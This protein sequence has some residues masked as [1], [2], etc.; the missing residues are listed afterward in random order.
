MGL[1]IKATHKHK[2]TPRTHT[3]AINTGS[4]CPT[5][6]VRTSSA[7]SYKSSCMLKGISDAARFMPSCRLLVLSSISH[8][9][10]FVK[11]NT[12]IRC[13]AFNAQVM[14]DDK[15]SGGGVMVIAR[16]TAS[17]SL[18]KHGVDDG[19]VWSACLGLCNGDPPLSPSTLMWPSTLSCD[20][21]PHIKYLDLY[22]EINSLLICLSLSLSLSHS[23][24]LSLSLSTL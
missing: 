12:R 14:K 18:I 22:T 5:T 16:L 3:R 13:A 10:V 2:L 7:C 11:G 4:F 24:S 8:C 1:L 15:W 17:V 6:A 19:K 20:I 9:F 21:L 23:R